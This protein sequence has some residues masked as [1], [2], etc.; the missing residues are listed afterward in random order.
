MKDK[1]TTFGLDLEK[2][3]RLLEVGSDIPAAPH[4]ADQQKADLLSDRLSD[5]LAVYRS[6]EEEG[7]RMPRRLRETIQALA[8]ESVGKL[9]LDSK[10]DIGLIRTAKAHGRK[11]S[12]SAKSKAEYQTANVIYYAAIAHALVRHDR[13]ITKHSYEY[14]QNSFIHLSKEDWIPKGL[15]D[16]FVEASEY[17]QAK[18]K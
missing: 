2:V 7:A 5:T 17:C 4:V 11:L 18:V 12:T 6:T 13:K 14:L 1:A 15:I 16:L 10:T 3:A 9:L 8:G